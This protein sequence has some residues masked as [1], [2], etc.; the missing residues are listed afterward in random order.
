MLEPREALAQPDYVGA[1][2]GEEFATEAHVESSPAHDVGHE[3]VAGDEPAARQGE[4][5][6]LEVDDVARTASAVGEVTL[7]A[8]GEAPL[9]GALERISPVGQAQTARE[10][11]EEI[12]QRQV[13]PRRRLDA[14]RLGLGHGDRAPRHGR[15]QHR[16]ELA[17]GG[18]PLHHPAE[19]V[20]V[21]VEE[22]GSHRRKT[23][24]ESRGSAFMMIGSFDAS[25]VDR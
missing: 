10:L 14:M 18:L 15:P 9:A 4:R 25:R 2:A 12:E 1:P 20:L 11:A 21:E 16:L 23:G 13:G 17:E 7:E 24:R 3:R 6:R 22:E 5:K 19:V 8:A